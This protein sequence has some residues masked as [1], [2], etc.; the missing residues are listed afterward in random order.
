MTR[1]EFLDGINSWYELREFCSDFGCD[2]CECIYSQNE[3]DE[4]IDSNLLDMARNAAGWEDLLSDLQDYPTGYDYYIRD[5]D[6][7]FVGVNESDFFDYKDEALEW[8]D[9]EGIFDDDEEDENDGYDEECD[10]IDTDVPEDPDDGYEVGNEEMSISELFVVPQDRNRGI[11][12][13]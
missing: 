2:V 9:D 1:D 11:Y 10:D 12:N 4:Y 3:M 8:A 13:I 5:D 7:D 6:G